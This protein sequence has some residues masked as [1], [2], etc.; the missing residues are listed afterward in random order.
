M[1]KLFSNASPLNQHSNELRKKKIVKATK[2]GHSID[3]SKF[4]F[5]NQLMYESDS[6]ALQKHFQERNGDFKE[7]TLP[8]PFGLS[9][10]NQKLE[11]SSTRHC[12]ALVG[13][14][15]IESERKVTSAEYALTWVAE[16]GNWQRSMQL[17]SKVENSECFRE[18]IHLTWL[19]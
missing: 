10:T 8:V 1:R 7:V 16:R 5:L 14:K 15:P 18:L 3:S 17:I 11:C 9:R 6:T 13:R 2:Q 4:R 12:Y 19:L